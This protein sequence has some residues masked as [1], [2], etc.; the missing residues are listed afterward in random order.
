[1]RLSYTTTLSM[2]LVSAVGC[3]SPFYAEQA[4]PAGLIEPDAVAATDAGETVD[5]PKPVP[6]TAD[7]DS[8]TDSGTDVAPA[9][10]LYA[11]PDAEQP[12]T[13]DFSQGLNP[14]GPGNPDAAVACARATDGDPFCGPYGGTPYAWTCNSGVGCSTLAL[15]TI[16]SPA[17]VT[18]YCCANAD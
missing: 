1:M 17:G 6:D 13:G 11:S 4:T 8:G 12:D 15:P 3:G 18:Y 16:D 2:L 9:P 7:V 14:S 5:A 10:P